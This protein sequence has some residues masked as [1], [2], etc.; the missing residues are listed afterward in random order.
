MLTYYFRSVKDEALKVVTEPRSGIWVHAVAPNEEEIKTLIDTFALDADIIEDSKDFYEVPR[1]ERSSGATYFFTRYPLADKQQ[2]NYTS[3]LLIV[4]GE[5]FVVTIALNKIQQFEDLLSGK[6]PVYTTQKSK[7][8]IQ[9]MNILTNSFDKELL[10]LRKAVH[11][12]RAKLQSIGTKEIEHLV[13]YENVLNSMIDTLLPTNTWLQQVTNGSYMQL[14]QDDV[15]EMEDLVIA[16]GQV[17]NSAR[18]ILKTVQNIRSAAEAIMTSRL[19]NALRILTVL[20][21]LMTV[22]L[23]IASLYGMNV[24]LPFQ[25]SSHTFYFVVIINIVLLTGLSYLFKR[26]R[27]F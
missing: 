24:S 10:R 11:K 14:Y 12:D 25:D 17:V 22:P 16:N 15:E 13:N 21:I 5:S 4:M 20:T 7:F 27:W 8:F 19:N 2:D 1:M 9:I 26:N 18:S 3:P 23:V 6:N